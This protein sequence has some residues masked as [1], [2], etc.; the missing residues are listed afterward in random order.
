MIT[1]SRVKI[2][3]NR[4]RLFQRVLRDKTLDLNT[5]EKDT[6]L[7]T[8]VSVLMPFEALQDLTIEVLKDYNQLSRFFDV[9]FEIVEYRIK[10]IEETFEYQFYCGELT[11]REKSID[12]E[13][14]KIITGKDKKQVNEWL[15]IN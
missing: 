13:N 5:D 3:N 1:N 9:P 12:I 10:H 4:I 7:D 11:E 2:H 6:L 8:L 15:E 14:G